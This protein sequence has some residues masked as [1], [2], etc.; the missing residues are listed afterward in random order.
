MNNRYRSE[1]LRTATFWLGPQDGLT[2]DIN[3]DEDPV[4]ARHRFYT[5]I[6]PQDPSDF[7][8]DTY[9]LDDCGNENCVYVHYVWTGVDRSTGAS[10]DDA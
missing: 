1:M 3:I 7:W 6:D 2:Y 8:I 4:L 10:D 9:E 5:N